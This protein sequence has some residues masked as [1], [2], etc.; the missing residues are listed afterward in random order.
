MAS[1]ESYVVVTSPVV[2]VNVTNSASPLTTVNRFQK[3]MTID[4]LKRKLELVTGITFVDMILEVYNAEDVLVF[5]MVEDNRILGS[6][7]IDSGMRIHVVDKTGRSH[8]EYDVSKVQKFEISDENYAQRKDTLRAFKEKMKVGQYK[9]KDETEKLEK[10]KQELEEKAKAESIKI[11][12][13][14]EVRVSNEMAKRGTIM[15]VGLTEFKPGYWIG[16]KYDEPLGKNDGSVQGK[17][18]FECPPKYG[19][20]IRPSQVA[21][22]DFPEIDIEAENLEM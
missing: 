15:Y 13:R 11:G 18:Y 8:V 6:Y 17:R 10:E 5:R 20:F 9:E 22:G 19:A 3:D 14:C 21:V 7:P 1:N 16:V 4:A 12:Q 2:S